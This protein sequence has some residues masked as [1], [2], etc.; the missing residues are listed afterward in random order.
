MLDIFKT[1][2]IPQEA[3]H[4]YSQI[5]EKIQKT[6]DKHCLS[7]PDWKFA[8]K[9]FGNSTYLSRKLLN[10]SHLLVESLKQNEL[11]QQKN[12]KDHYNALLQIQNSSKNFNELLIN[13]KNYKYKE[14]LRL[15]LQELHLFNQKQIYKEFSG[16]AYAITT[17][18]TKVLYK[19]I[20]H[21]YDLNEEDVG[22]FAI[23][24]MGKLGGMELNYSSDIDLIGLYDLDKQHKKISNHEIFDKLFRKI[25][26]VLSHQD[27]HGFLYR[28]DWDLRPEGKSGSLSNS[29]L[30]MEKYYQAFG[31]EWERQA[32]IKAN[33]IYQK[34]GVGNQF[35]DMMKHFTYR[36]YLDEKTVKKISDMKS[37]IIDHLNKNNTNG[38]N[39]KL[40][41]GGIRDV[42]FITQGLQLLYG[43]KHKELQNQNTLETL[44]VLMNLKIISP[45]QLQNLT[46]GYL[47]LRRVESAIQMENEQQTHVIKDTNEHK[48]KLA[49]RIGIIESDN[50]AVTLFQD[51]LSTTMDLIHKIFM[52]YYGE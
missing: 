33:V 23:I 18:V 46:T 49:R 3:N 32:Y 12:Y 6:D 38:L 45:S 4:F 27:E 50:Q 39:I 31:E 8:A 10:K 2:A 16:L 37:K 42:E 15:T 26:Q 35:L 51:E 41:K 1:S 24:A 19:E 20:I 17:I 52:E 34:E 7:H 14:Y 48:L 25:T 40:A 28:V 21:S 11:Q 47:F 36:K 29:F 22:G 9:I 43:G 13:F 30:A 44:E 5:L